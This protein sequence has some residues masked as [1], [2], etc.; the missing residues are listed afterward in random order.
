MC[1]RKSSLFLVAFL[2]LFSVC[3][4]F[5][6]DVANMTEAEIISE[7]YENLESRESILRESESLL[8]TRA[9]LLSEQ[10]ADLEKRE[11]SLIERELWLSSRESSL[12][13]TENSFKSYAS[14]MK[15]RVDALIAQRTIAFICAVS[16]SIIAAVSFIFF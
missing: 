11:T 6:Q 13:A 16:A 8:R 7:L 1:S 12:N 14:A 9:A 10:E 4:S 2:L 15:D 3:F 5:A